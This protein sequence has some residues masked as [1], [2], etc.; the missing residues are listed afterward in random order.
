LIFSACV[1]MCVCVCVCVVAK[2]SAP[3]QLMAVSA[4]TQ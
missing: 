3:I 4:I 1:G 2:P